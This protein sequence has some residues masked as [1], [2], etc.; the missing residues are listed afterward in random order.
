MKVNKTFLIAITFVFCFAVA[1]HA[2]EHKT[3]TTTSSSSSSSS[4][5]LGDTLINIPSPEGYEEAAGQFEIIK[6]VFEA[7]E[8]PVN[9]LL[10]A[11]LPAADCKVARTGTMPPLTRY[12][13]VSVLRDVRG[14]S[15]TKEEMDAVVVEFRKN[16]AKLLDPDGEMLKS[17]ADNIEKNLAQLTPAS[18]TQLGFTQTQNL[19]EFDVRP[20]V[21]SVML[22][23]TYIMEVQGTPTTIPVLAS[24]TFLK[25]KNRLVYINAYKAISS[26]GAVKTELKPGVAELKQ[27]TTKWVN[28]ILAA[29][30]VAQ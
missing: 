11:H 20:E 7:T 30:R 10:F 23:M 25:V 19:G 28:E 5:W 22:F 2:Q 16:G 8:A 15:F 26:P 4:V 21:Y 18:K 14:H 1:A 6:K 13:K 27:F 3:K 29:N 24:L 12:T 17:L 9:D